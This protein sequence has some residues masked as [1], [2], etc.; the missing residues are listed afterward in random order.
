MDV[1]FT[2]FLHSYEHFCS[3]STNLAIL[4]MHQYKVHEDTCT[5]IMRIH[6]SLLF[7][8]CGSD[9]LILYMDYREV[10]AIF[11]TVWCFCFDTNA[12][13]TCMYIFHIQWKFGVVCNYFKKV[14]I[15]SI[16]FVLWKV[17]WQ[18]KLIYVKKTG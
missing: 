9:I 17:Y 12:L 1:Y 6:T 11:F 4:S 15:F 14:Y 2:A 10:C 5:M 7:E 13:C 3:T 16:V 18:L 8:Y